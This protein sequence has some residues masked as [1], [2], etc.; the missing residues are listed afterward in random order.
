MRF[1]NVQN[2]QHIYLVSGKDASTEKSHQ[3]TQKRQFLNEIG[4]WV[5]CW[6][7]E[8]EKYAFLNDI[9]VKAVRSVLVLTLECVPYG[10]CAIVLNARPTKIHST[11]LSGT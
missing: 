9:I 6:T 4:F 2:K 8:I 11:L 1:G 7:A 3:I 5:E 10:N